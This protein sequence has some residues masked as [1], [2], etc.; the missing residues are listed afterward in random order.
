[1]QALGGLWPRSRGDS[2]SGAGDAPPRTPR[3]RRT[4]CIHPYNSHVYRTYRGA[5]QTAPSQ[6][7]RVKSSAATTRL[8]HSVH[9]PPALPSQRPRRRLRWW[10]TGTAVAYF[11]ARSSWTS[12]ARMPSL[13]VQRQDLCGPRP[14]GGNSRPAAQRS[15]APTAPTMN[16]S[17][18]RMVVCVGTCCWLLIHSHPA[19]CSDPFA[20]HDG[21]HRVDAS[22]SARRPPSSRAQFKHTG[23]SK[24][25]SP[26]FF[27]HN[28][29]QLLRLWLS[30]RPCALLLSCALR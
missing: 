25:S 18:R 4:P 15:T 5:Q 7:E 21:V 27:T 28:K 29:I 13:K 22:T 14:K 23:G 12:L 20:D 6:D 24:F 26:L 16:A 9:P 11:S 30:M 2:H 10:T 8:D 19:L 1:M 17:W 3:D